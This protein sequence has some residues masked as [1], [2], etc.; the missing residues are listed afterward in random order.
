MLLNVKHITA[1]SAVVF[2]KVYV[3]PVNV[4]VLTTMYLFIGLLYAIKPKLEAVYH[5]K[6]THSCSKILHLLN[7]YLAK[8]T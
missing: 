4:T 6:L 8:Y 5:D 2:Y 3:T 1:Y 7:L